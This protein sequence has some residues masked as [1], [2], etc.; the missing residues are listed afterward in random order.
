MASSLCKNNDY[1]YFEC[2]LFY[3]Y[4]FY[5]IHSSAIW[6]HQR[7]FLHKRQ[8]RHSLLWIANYSASSLALRVGVTSHFSHV[9]ICCM[10]SNLSSF[11]C[12]IVVNGL[13]LARD[14]ISCGHWSKPLKTSNGHP[15]PHSME[16]TVKP[17][18]TTSNMCVCVCDR[19]HVQWSAWKI[20]KSPHLMWW[21]RRRMQSSSWCK[22]KNGPHTSSYQP[23]AK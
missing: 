20:E 22:L 2:L 12:S 23:R 1:I 21:W 14:R 5:F 4:K 18:A 13:T 19:F 6:Y 15:S 16:C 8:R 17:N 9:R 10:A 7:E 3:Y 11:C